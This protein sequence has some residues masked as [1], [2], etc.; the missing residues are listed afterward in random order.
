MARLHATN[1]SERQEP[2]WGLGAV[3]DPVTFGEVLAETAAAIVRHPGPALDACARWANGM[4]R[5]GCATLSRTLGADVPGPSHPGSRDRRFVDPTWE[6]NPLYFG[7]LQGYLLS[8]QL[9][10]DLVGAA[11]LEPRRKL[12]AEFAA[13]HLIDA[14]APT[15]FLP[16]NPLALKRAFETGGASLA[17]GIR[18]FLDDL[19]SNGGWPRQVDP[20]AFTVGKDLASTPGK[21]IFRN[22]LIELIQYAPQTETV[23]EIPLLLSPP[24][25]N[26]YYVM[27]LAPG[28]SFAEWAL[29][30]GHTVFAISYRNPDESLRDVGMEQ[31]LLEGPRTAL[32]VIAEVTGARKANIVALCLGGT[33]AA[34]LAA[35]LAHLGDDRIRSMTLLNTLLDFSEP[36]PLGAFV[37]RVTV[38]RLE[39]RMEERGYLDASEMSGTFNLLRANDLV[40]N[41]VG[42]N[43]LMGES[44]QAFDILA[45]NRDSTRLPSRMHSEYLRRCYLENA[46]AT[47]AMGLAG[48][49]LRLAHITA[50]AYILAAFEDHIAP[51]RSGYRTTQL[52]G[53]NTRFVLSSSGH[54]AGIVNPPSP[55]RSHW[56]N[57]QLP[58]DPEVWLAGA[59]EHQGS[60]WDDW[61]AW[62]ETRAGARREPPPLGG[63]AHA[64][65]AEAPGTYVHEH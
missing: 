46:L 25:I 41:Y 9:L 7:L 34:M 23:F 17:R 59:E 35:H 18:N 55:K 30:H 3:L 51:W 47:G 27:D 45:W 14:L 37:D 38:E 58:P 49:P 60:W 57:E 48:T 11:E 63:A 29:T 15:N 22:R 1:G 33:L 26:K 56:T 54:I 20:E 8:A 39:K 5:A 16:G 28:K 44:P 43:W 31:Y 32:D 21:V 12:K 53:G 42:S 4:A 19:T 36:G 64:A 52:L 65:L 2:T 13:Q 6:G 62:I 61:A 24:W 40:W 50:D 10:L